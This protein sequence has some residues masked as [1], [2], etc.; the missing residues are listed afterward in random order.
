MKINFPNSRTHRRR[1][2]VRSLVDDIEDVI[3]MLLVVGVDNPKR[4]V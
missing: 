1:F 4:W 2:E 3:L